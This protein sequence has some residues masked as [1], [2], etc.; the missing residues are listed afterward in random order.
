[1][2]K[3]SSFSQLGQRSNLSSGADPLRISRFRNAVRLCA[4]LALIAIVVATVSPP[5]VRP[6]L[7]PHSANLERTIAFATLGCLLGAGYR[8]HR[9]LAFWF[10][11]LSALGLELAQL[12][13][14][15]RHARVVEAGVKACAGIVGVAIGSVVAGMV[16]HKY[17][18]PR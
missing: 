18:N 2:L 14:A 9:L 7:L 11:S 5:E 12:L 8:C 3:R 17:R 10:V 6:L 16:V 13:V 1:M 15:D 4:W